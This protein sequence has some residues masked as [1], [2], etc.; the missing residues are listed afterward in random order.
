M[1][2]PRVSVIL[3]SYRRIEALKRTLD[4]FRRHVDLSDY[5]LII[6]DD[7]SA[8][9]QRREIERMGADKFIWNDRVGYGINTNRGIRAASGEFLFHLEDD[10]EIV[11]TG[12]FLEAGIQVLRAL[13]EVG[14]INYTFE[15]CLPKLRAK[16]Q[17]GQYHVEILPFPNSQAKGYAIFR[18]SNRPHLKHRRFHEVYGLYPEGYGHA[19]TELLFVAHVNKRRGSRIAWIRDSVAFWHIGP[20]YGTTREDPIKTRPATYYL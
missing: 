3:L 16:R 9:W 14:C 6:C 8:D 10:L 17:V 18:Y 20:E 1:G 5:E 19:A 13:P 15:S 4:S 7:G 2:K 12:Y 11:S